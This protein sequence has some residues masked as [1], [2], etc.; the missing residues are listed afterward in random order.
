MKLKPLTSHIESELFLSCTLNSLLIIMFVN[1]GI[2][3]IFFFSF[4]DQ[5]EQNDEGGEE[6]ELSTFMIDPSCLDIPEIPIF[7]N[8]EGE[9]AEMGNF[10]S[11]LLQQF[12]NGEESLESDS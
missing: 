5:L 3:F 7:N 9:D 1:P 6:F 8:N 2:S 10:L 4:E 12:N 11:G